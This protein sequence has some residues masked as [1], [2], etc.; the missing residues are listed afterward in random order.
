MYEL[1]RG[2]RGIPTH[3]VTFLTVPRRP[4]APNPNRDELVE[5]DAERLFRQLREDEP[6]TVT[7]PEATPSAAARAPATAAPT[8]A[9]TTTDAVPEGNS[10]GEGTSPPS[11]PI[12]TFTGTTAGNTGCR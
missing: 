1:V 8:P 9:A 10:A 6:V 12:P 4:Y 5:P 7:P 3:R 2:V 11:A